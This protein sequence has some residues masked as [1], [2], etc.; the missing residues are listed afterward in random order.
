MNP[1]K[2]NLARL[3]ITFL[4]GSTLILG[5]HLAHASTEASYEI[6]Q[7]PNEVVVFFNEA[8]QDCGELVKNEY[9]TFFQEYDYDLTKS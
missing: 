5:T 2:K 1:L 9:P 4:A 8:C 7:A 6:E 3:L